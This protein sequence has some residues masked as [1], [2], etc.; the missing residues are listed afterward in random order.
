MGNFTCILRNLLQILQMTNPV[1]RI[2]RGEELE[3][4]LILSIEKAD[5]QTGAERSR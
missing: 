3:R 1:D 2:H 4:D 5:R